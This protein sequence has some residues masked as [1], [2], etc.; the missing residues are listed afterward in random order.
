MK[1][2]L[3]ALMISS[4]TAGATLPQTPLEPFYHQLFNE[5]SDLANSQLINV[6]PQLNSEAQRT[7]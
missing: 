2:C 3:F 1:R 5:R 6:W 4:V 7:A